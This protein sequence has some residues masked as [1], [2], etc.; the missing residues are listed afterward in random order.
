MHGFPK[1]SK[2]SEKGWSRLV[3]SGMSKAKVR[4]SVYQ[5]A[6]KLL[7]IQARQSHS[8]GMGGIPQFVS[9]W[10]NWATLAFKFCASFLSSSSLRLASFPVRSSKCLFIS[11]LSSGNESQSDDLELKSSWPKKLCDWP[12][13][14]KEAS[15]PRK[16]DHGERWGRWCSRERRW[17]LSYNA[18][19]RQSVLNVSLSPT[20]RKDK[21][22]KL[23]RKDWGRN[24]WRPSRNLQ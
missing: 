15:L 8:N 2:D 13:I 10:R 14:S 22:K 1:K 5:L 17:R 19:H 7:F 21:H 3:S 23:K 16:K 18:K 6:Y 9:Q 4:Y 20:S 24:I 12:R 11:G